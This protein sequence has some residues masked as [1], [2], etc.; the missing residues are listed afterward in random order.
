MK[1]GYWFI[2]AG[3]VWAVFAFG[4]APGCTPAESILHAE[5]STAAPLLH[6]YEID[7]KVLYAESLESAS[8]SVASVRLNRGDK[9]IIVY[10]RNYVAG[11]ETKGEK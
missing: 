7:G 5:F 2:L 3:L 11:E 1:P 8:E 4:V 6:R 10:P 9:W